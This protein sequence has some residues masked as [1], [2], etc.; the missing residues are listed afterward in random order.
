M[1]FFLL[2]IMSFVASLCSAAGSERVP[3]LEDV[4]FS[5]VVKEAQK[6][7]LTA[8]YAMV[9]SDNLGIDFEMDEQL[10]SPV[11]DATGFVSL[12]L[13]FNHDFRWYS[14]GNPEEANVDVRSSA[15]AGV[16][17]NVVNYSGASASGAVSIDITDYAASDL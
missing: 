10:I 16:W 15:T 11:I 6:L 14:G 13:N 5:Q 3:W 7:G 9:D 1:K 12:S 17:V 8:P 2:F 4:S